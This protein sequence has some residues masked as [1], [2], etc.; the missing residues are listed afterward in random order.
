MNKLVFTKQARIDASHLCEQIIYSATVAEKWEAGDIR[1]WIL[2]HRKDWIVEFMRDREDVAWTKLVLQELSLEQIEIA[3]EC[4]SSGKFGEVV[5]SILFAY[6][7]KELVDLDRE[8]S[9]YL[10]ANNDFDSPFATPE[11]EALHFDNIERTDD[12]R[13][14]TQ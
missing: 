14:A 12:V 11:A 10:E 2:E 4:R 8:I 5:D 3:E 6:F 1:D 9:D 13:R 7:T